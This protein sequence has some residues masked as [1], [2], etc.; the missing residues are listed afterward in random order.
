MISFV[1]II[2]TSVTSYNYRFSLVVGIIK[3]QPISKFDDDNT[4]LLSIFTMLCTEG[5]ISYQL[6]TSSGQNP[7]SAQKPGLLP[8]STILYTVLRCTPFSEG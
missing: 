7:Q 1:A 4:T 8:A 3:I 5:K 2:S 6:Y